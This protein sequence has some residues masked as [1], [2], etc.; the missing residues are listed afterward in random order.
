MQKNQIKPPFHVAIV[1]DEAILK[2]EMAFQLEH[3]GFSVNTFESAPGF[4]RFL[5]TQ[6]NTVAVLDIGLPGDESGLD[7]CS[8]L[9]QNNPHMGIVFL[10]AQL[11]TITSRFQA[12]ML[13]LQ[14]PTKNDRTSESNLPIKP[15]VGWTP[16]VCRRWIVDV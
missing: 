14:I 11:M 3:H 4:Y 1:D 12:I 16:T 5:A 9:R 2:E 6:P 13:M 7:I 8:Y 15:D 10:T